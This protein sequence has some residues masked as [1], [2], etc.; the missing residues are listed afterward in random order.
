MK[1][2]NPPFLALALSFSAAA[3]ADSSIELVPLV[4]GLVN[5]LYVTH[6][7][8]S[9]LTARVDVFLQGTWTERV[10]RNRYRNEGRQLRLERHGRRALFPR[11]GEQL[12]H[13]RPDSS[14]SRN[15]EVPPSVE[16]QLTPW[17]LYIMIV[18]S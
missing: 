4:S 5:P 2:T 14:D 13:D 15:S 1:S 12:Q 11:F 18:L 7:G 9:R 17:A 10:G 3:H 16:A 8:D 6:C